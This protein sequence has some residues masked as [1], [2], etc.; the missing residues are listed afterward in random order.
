MSNTWP[1]SKRRETPKE[2][3]RDHHHHAGPLR[4][5]PHPGVVG[6]PPVTTVDCD[7]T[8][9][10]GACIVSLDSSRKGYDL[11]PRLR[12]EDSM[13]RVIEPGPHATNRTLE[14]WNHPRL[15]DPA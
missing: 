14:W 3:H 9:L 11:R 8:T 12:K 10:P 5:Q 6:R 7:L 13:I 15:D 2:D 1:G 4:H